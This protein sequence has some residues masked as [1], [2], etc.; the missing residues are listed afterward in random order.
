MARQEIELTSFG[1]AIMRGLASGAYLLFV[2]AIAFLATQYVRLA[3]PSYYDDVWGIFKMGGLGIILVVLVFLLFVMVRWMGAQLEA[4]MGRDLD[5]D[6]TIGGFYGVGTG[7][8]RL[9]NTFNPTVREIWEEDEQVEHLLEGVVI[10]AGDT[11]YR[12]QSH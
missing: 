1:E 3:Y 5:Q 9:T 7:D 11:D 10:D 4:A 2:W 12:V 8:S 6:G